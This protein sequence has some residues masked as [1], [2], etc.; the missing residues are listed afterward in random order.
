M[1][2][3][4]PVDVWGDESTIGLAELAVRTHAPPITSVKEGNV[5][6]WDDFESST[7]KYID[8]VNGLGTIGRSADYARMGDF[9]L[10]CVTGA[11]VDNY[12]GAYHFTSNFHVHKIGTQI[13]FASS[14][15]GYAAYTSITY[16][17]GTNLHMGGL[18]W[19]ESTGVL[20]YHG[21][22]GNFHDLTP[23][24]L[25]EVYNVNWGTLKMKVDLST[26]KYI[27]AHVFGNVYDL[28]AY[29]LYDAADASAKQ[30]RST[31]YIKTLAAASKTAYF[32]NYIL[33]EYGD[34]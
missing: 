9:S 10:K 33:L 18:K 24:V 5:L 16:Y 14:G 28:S 27:S 31:N 15:T 13:D 19:T 34:I 11:V 17:D 12:S 7:Q 6:E 21:D 32:D 30:L 2:V 8:Y 22:D 29:S 4:D 26:N 23:I 1:F 3:K 20:S 25:R